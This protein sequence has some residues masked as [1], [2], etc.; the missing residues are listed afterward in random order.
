MRSYNKISRRMGKGRNTSFK[1]ELKQHKRGTCRCMFYL[2]H[3]PRLCVS[4]ALP[5]LQGGLGGYGRNG[6][7]SVTNCCTL[8]VQGYR[9]AD[10]ETSQECQLIP[11]HCQAE[12]TSRNY[13]GRSL[14]QQE[15]VLEPFVW[16]PKAGFSKLSFHKSLIKHFPPSQV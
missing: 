1:N 10:E 12:R 5:G 9:G 7:S 11:T 3:S 4:T 2:S 6:D 8:G 15:V 16:E 13:R 14:S